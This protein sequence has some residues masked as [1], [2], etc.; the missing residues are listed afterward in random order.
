M[1]EGMRVKFRKDK[2]GVCRRSE[3]W[4]EYVNKVLKARHSHRAGNG[5]KEIT[6]L[7]IFL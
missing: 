7:A 4:W 1:V 2:V 3:K 5:I 6:C